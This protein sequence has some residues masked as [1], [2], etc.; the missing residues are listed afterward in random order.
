VQVEVEPLERRIV[1]LVERNQEYRLDAA[2]TLRNLAERLVESASEN[3]APAPADT[4]FQLQLQRVDDMLETMA[5]LGERNEGLLAS[6]RHF[7]QVRA[8][9]N[10]YRLDWYVLGKGV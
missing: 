5:A 8:F 2:K 7:G 9:C 10:A 1:A 4:W 3:T 6:T